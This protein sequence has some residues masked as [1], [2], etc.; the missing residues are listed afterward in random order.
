MAASVKQELH[1]LAD[2]LPENATWDEVI[3]A[4]CYR[5]AVEAGIYAADRESLPPTRKFTPLLP[6]RAAL[7]HRSNYK[8]QQ[9]A[10]LA[11]K[12]LHL[13]ICTL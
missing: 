12:P 11:Q 5:R 6:A 1:Q 7:Q 9:P 8:R 13:H 2:A 10:G 3:E 4:A